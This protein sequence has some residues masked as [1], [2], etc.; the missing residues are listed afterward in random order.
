MLLSPFQPRLFAGF[1]ILVSAGDYEAVNGRDPDS[2]AMLI[3]F[4]LF[5]IA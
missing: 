3:G 5:H 4:G 1:H 2:E